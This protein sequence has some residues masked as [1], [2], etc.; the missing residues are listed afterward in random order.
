MYNKETLNVFQKNDSPNLTKT[1]CGLLK[2]WWSIGLSY[3]FSCFNS[4]EGHKRLSWPF[5]G[6]LWAKFLI[7]SQLSLLLNAQNVSYVIVRETSLGQESFIPRNLIR[8]AGQLL[9]FWLCF[10]RKDLKLKFNAPDKLFP[11]FLCH[12]S[13]ASKDTSIVNGNSHPLI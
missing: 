6:Y 10:L 12:G 1:S 3:F 5:S 13:R 9:N 11:Y 8:V 4:L 7:Y 2:D